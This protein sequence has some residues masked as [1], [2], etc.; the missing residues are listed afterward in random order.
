MKNPEFEQK[1]LDLEAVDGID[2]SKV[3]F[4][5]RRAHQ[6]RAEYV[7]QSLSALLRPA[8]RAKAAP[9][10]KLGETISGAPA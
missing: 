3:D 9:A 1:G 6:L 5:V 8:R 2:P 4:Y 10:P 7:A